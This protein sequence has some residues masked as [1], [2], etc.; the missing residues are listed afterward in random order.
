M[1]ERHYVVAGSHCSS[2]CNQADRNQGAAAVVRLTWP[3]EV[4]VATAWVVMGKLAVLLVNVRD[5]VASPQVPVM[6]LGETND[7]VSPVT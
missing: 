6:L 2:E 7:A 3:L 4:M 5:A 1:P